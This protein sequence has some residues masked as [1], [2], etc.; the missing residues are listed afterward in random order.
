MVCLDFLA[1]RHVASFNALIVGISGRTVVIEI[2]YFFFFAIKDILFY[3]HEILYIANKN[4][5][6]SS[7]FFELAYFE[8]LHTLDTN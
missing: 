4:V 2:P 5:L 7:L 8:N 1:R 6:F 3:Y